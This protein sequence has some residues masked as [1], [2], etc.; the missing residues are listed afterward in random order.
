MSLVFS[1][2]LKEYNTLSAAISLHLGVS[3]ELS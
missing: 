2:R 1:D 3:I